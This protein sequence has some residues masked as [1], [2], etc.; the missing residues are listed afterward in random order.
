MSVQPPERKEDVDHN[1]D[2]TEPGVLNNSH[3]KPKKWNGK[4]ESLSSVLRT[5]QTRYSRRKGTAHTQLSK[6]DEKKYGQHHVL[7]QYPPSDV[8]FFYRSL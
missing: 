2:S 1:D 5:C 4:N 6:L 3:A 8:R 7:N